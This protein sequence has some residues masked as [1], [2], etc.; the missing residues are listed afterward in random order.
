MSNYRDSLGQSERLKFEP[1]VAET[2]PKPQQ[3]R[4]K[5]H[6]QLGGD[7]SVQRFNR[8]GRLFCRAEIPECL[9]Q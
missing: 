7:S 8:R 5:S 3:L 1:V 2:T 4:D 6:M 9:L